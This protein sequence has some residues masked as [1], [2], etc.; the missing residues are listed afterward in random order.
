MGTPISAATAVCKSATNIFISSRHFSTAT[1]PPPYCSSSSPPTILPRHA[2]PAAPRRAHGGD[3]SLPP[4]RRRR[5]RCSTLIQ[6]HH[7][8]ARRRRV[9]A[10]RASKTAPAC[11]VVCLSKSDACSFHAMQLIAVVMLCLPAL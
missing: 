10:S 7:G 1:P 8:G 3:A 11:G 6:R 2:H 5:C 4:A 9:S